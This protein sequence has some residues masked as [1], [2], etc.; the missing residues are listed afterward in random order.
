MPISSPSAVEIAVLF[1]EN[2]RVGVPAFA[3]RYHVH[4][5]E[6]S[7]VIPVAAF[8]ELSVAGVIVAVLG[9]ESQPFGKPGHEFQCLG[10]FV[11]ERVPFDIAV[12]N[13]NRFNG[14]QLCQIFKYFVLVL[15]HYRLKQKTISD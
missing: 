1:G 15:D 2:Q 8:A 6:H 7:G 14:D 3:G 9:G 13:G 4:M 5:A 11:S 10:R 12:R